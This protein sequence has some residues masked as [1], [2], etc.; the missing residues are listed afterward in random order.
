MA[1]YMENN[2]TSGAFTEDRIKVIKLLASQASIS[3]ENARIYERQEKLLIAQQR[4]VPIQFLKHLGHEDITK[5]ELGE[6]VSMEMTVLFTDIWDFTPLSEN[7]SP[8]VIIQFLNRLFNEMGICIKAC[9]GF[10][11][12]YAGDQ[13]MALFI[14]PSSN[15]IHAGI[16]MIHALEDFNASSKEYS[17]PPIKIGLGV[18]TGPL[19]LGTM[20]ANERMQCSV[21]GDTVNLASRIERLTRFYGA[22]F[23]MGEQ[24]YNSLENPNLFSTRVV[25]YVAVKGKGVATKLYEILDAENKERR[26]TKEKTNPY[27]I[28][29]MEA[30][31]NREFNEA[32]QIFNDA[33]TLD[34]EDKVFS[35]F[36]ARSKKYMDNPPD[37]NWK[38]FEQLEAK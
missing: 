27:L 35:I 7:L 12:S 3:M 4:F 9:E 32:Y 24:T 17:L 19:V 8:Q 2:L 23:L 33:N 18:N 34:P 37:E 36:M 26:E 14:L 29:G 5:V 13:I 16:K 38:G 10:I 31:Y 25:D 22:K 28:K 6:S 20:G 30:F 15:A 21:L 11:D 1:I